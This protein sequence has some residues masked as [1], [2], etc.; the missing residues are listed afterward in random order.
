MKMAYI[1]LKSLTF[2]ASLVP[3]MAG[4]LLAT[5]NFHEL[6]QISTT[7][8]LMFGETRPHMLI[9]AGVFGIGLREAV[10]K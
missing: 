5:E 8:R 6:D 10:G 7:I 2:W 1:K 9:N 4:L 3:L